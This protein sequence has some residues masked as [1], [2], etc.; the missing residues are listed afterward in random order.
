MGL[1]TLAADG[2]DP[3]QIGFFFHGTTVATNALLEERGARVGLAVTDGFR[4]IQEAM[5]Q[6]RPYGRTI[7]DLRFQK[8][9]LL[10]PERRTAEIRE[11]VG[12]RGQVLREL[13]P[14]SIA[15]AITRFEAE[16]VEAVAICFLFSFMNPGARAGGS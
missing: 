13:D 7:F 3:G 8:P 2:V 10:A 16:R 14:A 12:A 11:R 4:G 9:A 1:E 6:S 15:E 5:E